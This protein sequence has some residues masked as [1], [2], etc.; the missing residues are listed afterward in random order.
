MT[1]YLDKFIIGLIIGFVVLILGT[2]T[3]EHPITYAIQISIGLIITVF[4]LMAWIVKTDWV[5]FHERKPKV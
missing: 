3:I 5:I 1:R 4:S 2:L